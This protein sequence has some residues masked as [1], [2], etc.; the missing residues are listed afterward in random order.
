MEFVPCPTLQEHQNEPLDCKEERTYMSRC[1]RWTQAGQSH[2]LILV[3]LIPT[4]G[5]SR[6]NQQLNKGSISNSSIMRRNQSTSSQ[7]VRPWSRLRKCWTIS[8]GSPK[9]LYNGRTPPTGPTS[10]NIPALKLKFKLAQVCRPIIV[11]TSAPAEL[12][13]LHR[14]SSIPI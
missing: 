11:L 14:C 6:V 12:H 2:L 4:N 5:N 8:A 10:M 7:P 9:I 3:F 13:R 1:K